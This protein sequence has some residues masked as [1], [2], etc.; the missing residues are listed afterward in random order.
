ALYFEKNGYEEETRQKIQVSAERREQIEA[1][2]EETVRTYTEAL[3][4]TGEEVPAEEE[5]EDPDDGSEETSGYT[6]VILDPD[7]LQGYDQHIPVNYLSQIRDGS[8]KVTVYRNGDFA[9][10]SIT[11][12]HNGW[13][14]IVW[15]SLP[16]EAD[17]EQDAASLISFMIR[18]AKREKRYKGVFLEM[19][20]SEYTPGM[21]EVLKAAGMKV[22][23]EKNNNYEFVLSDVKRDPKVLEVARKIVCTPIGGLDQDAKG[24]IEAAI[25]C[26]DDP[27][28]V[29]IPIPW[30]SFD[31]EL[32]FAYCG[33]AQKIGLLLISRRADSLIIDLLHGSN[34]LIAAALLGSAL[35]KLEQTAAPDQK[36]LVPIVVEASRPLL[37]K[38]VDGARRGDISEAVVR[39]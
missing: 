31:E 16:E 36:F 10:L 7:G 24:A 30:V 33:G 35:T 19:H 3:A 6:A 2:Y 34:P 11:G 15:I 39:F 5:T 23:A 28:P 13:V 9:G 37:E 18:S 20:Q 21:A 27:I 32:S 22:Y 12:V 25:Y 17:K 8:L 1:E 38:L 29:S 26:S 4:G 14:E